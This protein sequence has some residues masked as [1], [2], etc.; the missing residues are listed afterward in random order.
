MMFHEGCHKLSGRDYLA[1]RVRGTA[2]FLAKQSFLIRVST[3]A[4]LPKGDLSVSFFDPG[5]QDF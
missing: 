5:S 3:R 1:S 4:T 2:R